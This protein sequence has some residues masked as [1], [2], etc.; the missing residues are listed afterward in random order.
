L[1]QNLRRFLGYDLQYFATIEPQRR[2]APHAHMALRGTISRA[3]LRRV[4][5]ATYHQVWWPTTDEIRFDDD[6]L[7][8]WDEKRSRY[9]DPATGEQLPS[10]DE[11]LD[12]IGPHDQPLHV[13]RLGR[14][15]KGKGVLA[16]S[17]N[18]ARCIGYIT[19]YL[20]K[21]LGACHSPDT[22]AQR[23][24][25]ERLMA[26]LRHEPC[27]PTCANWLRYG[28]TPK[29]PRKGL[30]PS[31]CKG[32]AHRPEHLGYA[33]RRVLVSRK[34]SGK[35]LADHRGDRKAWLMDTL[36]L[37]AT[38]D[39]GRYQWERVTTA[40][41]DY[42]SPPRRLVRVVAERMRWKQALDEARRRAQEQAEDASVTRRA[43]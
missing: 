20:V 10:W 29:N 15:F 40:D 24:H 39:T 16:G 19:K 42:L 22:D 13:A 32:K 38:D 14:E 18:S 6:Q 28:I 37:S 31:Y 23:E 43:A 8:V 17:K 11:A 2:L 25:T 41:A 26:A 21:D 9:L 27:S 1:I 34:W 3:D 12:A 5:D 30:V 7:P 33:G 4:I 36:G 35:T